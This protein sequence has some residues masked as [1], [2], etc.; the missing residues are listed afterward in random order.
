LVINFECKISEK[1]TSLQ[2]KLSTTKTTKTLCPP[3]FRSIWKDK[4]STEKKPP[5]RRRK[6]PKK[7]CTERRE[8]TKKEKTTPTTT[9]ESPRKPAPPK[10]AEP[11]PTTNAYKRLKAI[12]NA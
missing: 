6:A 1:K 11:K 10:G 8:V 5:K 4:N 12:K 2:K 7:A 9:K 3:A